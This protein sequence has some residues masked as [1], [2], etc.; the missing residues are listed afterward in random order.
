M[1][2][3]VVEVEGWKTA[4]IHNFGDN[5]WDEGNYGKRVRG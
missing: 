1:K 4:V 5:F 3:Y 2:G